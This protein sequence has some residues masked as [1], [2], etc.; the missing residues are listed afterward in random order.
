MFPANSLWEY[1]WQ[2]MDPAS[3]ERPGKQLLLKMKDQYHTHSVCRV[4]C[5]YCVWYWFLL[6]LQINHKRWKVSKGPG[7]Q[8]QQS[9]MLVLFFQMVWERQGG[10]LLQYIKRQ[11]QDC[12]W[13]QL[14]SVSWEYLLMWHCWLS[15][16]VAWE[17]EWGG[18][19]TVL[20]FILGDPASCQLLLWDVWDFL[21]LQSLEEEPN[22]EGIIALPCFVASVRLC[23]HPAS[24]W[25]RRQWSQFVPLL[26]NS[27]FA[28]SHFNILLKLEIGPGGNKTR[29]HEYNIHGVHTSLSSQCNVLIRQGSRNWQPFWRGQK[30]PQKIL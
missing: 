15:L 28:L 3:E 4:H 6:W 2:M 7:W 21:K 26:L 16:K 13:L 17:R 27:C 10:E 23:Q 20:I 1:D 25:A 14:I 22:C 11:L 18:G 19:N 29:M 9:K 12:C 8:Q 30:W 24:N 5:V